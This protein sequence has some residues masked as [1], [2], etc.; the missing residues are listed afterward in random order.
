MTTETHRKRFKSQDAWLLGSV[1]RLTGTKQC[2]VPTIFLKDSVSCQERKHSNKEQGLANAVETGRLF[3][4]RRL[5]LT[6]GKL[7]NKSEIRPDDG[8]EL[9]SLLAFPTSR[10]ELRSSAGASLRRDYYS[11]R[12]LSVWQAAMTFVL[13][14]LS[15]GG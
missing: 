10:E 8:R 7:I 9:I 5:G 6:G 4:N 12:H 11:E 15:K 3:Q 14:T 1:V 2:A 13:R